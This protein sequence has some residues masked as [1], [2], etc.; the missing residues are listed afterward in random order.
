[1]TRV[2]IDPQTIIDHSATGSYPRKGS[3]PSLKIARAKGMAI[4]PGRLLC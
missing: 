3:A 1:M 4:L 2:E